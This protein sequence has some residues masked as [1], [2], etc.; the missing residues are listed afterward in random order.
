[1][2]EAFLSYAKSLQQGVFLYMADDHHSKGHFTN[3]SHL[4]LMYLSRSKQP[5]LV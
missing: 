3:T 4:T 1:M 5:V 2:E